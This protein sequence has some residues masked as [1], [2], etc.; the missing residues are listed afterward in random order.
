MLN[1]NDFANTLDM[2]YA[3]PI[4]VPCLV[5][6]SNNSKV[7]VP[8]DSDSLP[9]IVKS[10]SDFARQNIIGLIEFGKNAL[11]G[12]LELAKASES[13]RGYEVFGSL[14]NT[15]IDANLKLIELQDKRNK[16]LKDV[17]VPE[18]QTNIQ[19]N[20]SNTVYVGSTSELLDMLKSQT[21][22]Y[23]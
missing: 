8:S 18:N 1:P 17:A 4:Q 9:D 7:I 22:Q 23:P 14:M 6:L 16:A 3:E 5:E 19:N 11:Q 15:M 20:V 13:A 21:I 10:D 2:E 12:S